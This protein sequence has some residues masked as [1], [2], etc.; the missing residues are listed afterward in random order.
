M[1]WASLTSQEFSNVE[2]NV[3]VV[4]NIAAIEQHG[5]HLPVSTD[6]TIGEHFLTRM[7]DVLGEKVLTLPQIKVCCSAHHMSFDGTLT[8]SHEAF[9][10][11]AFEVVASVISHGFHNIVIFNSHGGNLAIGQVLVEK[12]GGAYPAENFAMLTWWKVA[13]DELAKIRE[14]GPGGVGHACEFET[15][16]LLHIDQSLVR[17]D[18]VVDVQPTF[19]FD[20]ADGDMMTGSAGSIHR[21]MS[22]LTSGTGV[23]G[24]P[25]LG[26]PEKGKAI[27]DV[28][29]QKLVGMI[30]DMSS[31][32]RRVGKYVSST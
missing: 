20:W 7:S 23:F 27:S 15:S 3:P 19:P 10:A 30:A 13:A 14:S 32:E 28:V 4:L 31:L 2:R 8:V 22:E 1:K 21:T 5:P 18:L 16:L 9:L 6:S 26:A 11:Y 17:N 12:L 29:S 25:S 24:T